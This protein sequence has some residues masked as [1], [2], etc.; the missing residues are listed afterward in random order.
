MKIILIV[1]TR[2]ELIKIAPIALRLNQLGLRGKYAIVNTAQ[3]K[4]LLEPYWKAFNLSADYSLDAM[5]PGQSLSNLT[6][7]L[8]IQIQDLFDNLGYKPL[9][10]VAQGDTTTVLTASMVC[11][12]NKIPFIHVEAGLR[13]FDLDNPFP[14]EYNRKLASVAASIHFAPTSKSRDNLVKEGI[15]GEK[16]EVT[17][18]TVVD[19]LNFIKESS[20]FGKSY[21]NSELAL[22]L[23]QSAKVVLI[24][25]HRR[26]N[27]GQNLVEIVESVDFLAKK[28]H[29]LTFVWPVHPNPN[30][31]SIISSSGL[32]QNNNVLIIP[33]VEYWDLLMLMNQSVLLLT[34]SGGIQEEAPS[35]NV[36]VLVLRNVTERP[37]GVESGISIL[38][39]A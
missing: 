24:T 32:G 30:V 21:Q 31:V 33:P 22:R 1:G 6:A 20:N 37:E 18:N 23:K 34:D 3:H 19:A 8:L 14:E 12:Y 13:S 16:I 15:P 38:V 17:G 2:P 7:R 25:S 11:F 35:F 29:E 4:D 28:Y 5:V 9:A 26:E 39:G 10:V 36:P 27:H